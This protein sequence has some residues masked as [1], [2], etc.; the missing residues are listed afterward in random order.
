MAFVLTALTPEKYGWAYC[1]TGDVSGV[2]QIRAAPGA[3]YQLVVDSIFIASGTGGASAI[4]VGTGDAASPT[5]ISAVLV[6]PVDVAYSPLEIPF[7]RPIG[8]G[9][10]ASLAVT[11][12]TAT[13]VCVVVEGRTEAA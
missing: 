1:I 7:T 8:L 4:T 13:N 2:E 5:V 10:N 6:G 3:G 9:A 12:S 11:S